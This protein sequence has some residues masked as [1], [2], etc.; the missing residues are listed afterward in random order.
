MSDTT[1]IDYI[2]PAVN[3][4][5]LNEI[6]DHVWHDVPVSGVV[7]HQATKIGV[8]PFDD[9]ASTTV[10]TALKEIND[11]IV[12]LMISVLDYGAIGNGTTDDS[13]AFQNTI[14]AALGKPIHI[15]AGTYKITIPLIY[16]TI[17]D[18]D[19]ESIKFIGDGKLLSLIDNQTGGICLTATSGTSNTDFQ[20]NIQLE[21]FSIINTTA[22][23]G[24]I[25]VKLVG[26][27]SGCV[28]IRIINQASHGIWMESS[29]NDATD[30][31]DVVFENGEY[32][33]NGGWGIYAHA[34]LSGVFANNSF[35]NN[36][37]I[38][39]TSGGIAY[40]SG[41]SS[42]FGRNVYAYNN[43]P[44][45]KF[46]KE[47]TGSYG[48]NCAIN[49]P[50][51]YDSNNGAQIHV[52]GVTNLSIEHSFF[53]VNTGTG[54]T[55]DSGVYIKDSFNVRIQGIQPR[56][57]V[58]YTGIELFVLDSTATNTLI[59]DTEYTSWEASGNTKYTNNSTTTTILE[60]GAFISGTW[61][62]TD[63]SGA[64]LTFTNNGSFYTRVGNT[65]TVATS[66]TFPSTVNTANIVITGLP[67]IAR[68]PC[69]GVLLQGTA[70]AG[71]VGFIPATTTSIYIYGTSFTR[72][73][74]ANYSTIALYFTATYLI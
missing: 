55:V 44:G 23:A 3:A 47:A 72:K 39:N 8:T 71:D 46:M 19:V 41:A 74:N 64:T 73:T 20:N 59:L 42:S 15:P 32:T 12:P 51:E 27:R 10:Q 67:F 65:V 18:G 60:Q 57:A 4:E 16:D 35:T 48:K 54:T 58:G 63:A 13:V 24:T 53:V 33:S 28:N 69:T 9:I 29:T 17:G 26:I 2:Q 68:C 11:K 30:V 36:R 61:I 56:I 62:P 49:E 40:Y 38:S 37:F 31:F 21:D 34:D 50:E 70:S 14:N 7:V 22:S 25:G 43:G 6:N 45:L 1:Y 66:M 5:W 52:E